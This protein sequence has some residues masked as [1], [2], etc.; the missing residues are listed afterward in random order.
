MDDCDDYL[1]N[2]SQGEAPLMGRGKNGRTYSIAR[3][4]GEGAWVGVRSIPGRSALLPTRRLAPNA[5][6]GLPNNLIVGEECLRLHSL[7]EAAH[8]R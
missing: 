7:P 8:E 6:L 3:D 4:Q 1:A 5:I 2:V